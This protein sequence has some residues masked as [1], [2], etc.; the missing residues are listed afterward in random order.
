MVHCTV[1]GIVYQVKL[2]YIFNDYIVFGKR[3]K[4]DFER[5]EKSLKLAIFAME[6]PVN[7]V[8]FFVRTLVMYY[9]RDLG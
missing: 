8:K 7:S 4:S 6:S 2:P 5:R 1:N 9:V 3:L